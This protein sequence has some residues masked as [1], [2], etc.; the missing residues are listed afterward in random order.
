M[1]FEEKQDS[2][3]RDVFALTLD[4]SKADASK[5]PPIIHMG[6]LAQVLQPSPFYCLITTL[7]MPC[8]GILVD[9]EMRVSR[10]L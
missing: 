10:S 8:H 9:I 2:L 3:I 7:A 5:V 4:G 6:G 1:A